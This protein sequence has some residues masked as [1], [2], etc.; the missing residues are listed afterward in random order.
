MGLYYVALDTQKPVS[1]DVDYLCPE[2]LH[3]ATV[4]QVFIYFFENVFAY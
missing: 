1:P 3:W 4:E 2:G